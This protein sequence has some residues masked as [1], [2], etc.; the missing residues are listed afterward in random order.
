M[1]RSTLTANAPLRVLRGV[2]IAQTDVVVLPP[3]LAG[4]R[5]FLDLAAASGLK[6]SELD[7]AGAYWWDRKIPRDLLSSARD[8]KAA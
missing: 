6:F 1:T 5:Q 3:T 7:E 2:Q 8:A 4:W